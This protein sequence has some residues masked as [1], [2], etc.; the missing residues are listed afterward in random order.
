MSLCGEQSVASG[1]GVMVVLIEQFLEVYGSISQNIYAYAYL[2]Q[3]HVAMM[4]CS[5]CRTG[6]C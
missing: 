2:A 4:V 3:K 1:R 6:P 5:V